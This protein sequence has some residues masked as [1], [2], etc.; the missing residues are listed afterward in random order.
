M[1]RCADPAPGCYAARL[2]LSHGERSGIS[3]RIGPAPRSAGFRLRPFPWRR[4]RPRRTG[5]AGAGPAEKRD[6]SVTEQE[7]TTPSP[8]GSRDARPG[9]R[10]AGARAPRLDA[11]R[12]PCG[13]RGHHRRSSA[14]GSRRHVLRMDGQPF[15]VAGPAD[16]GHLL[17]DRGS[18]CHGRLSPPAHPPQLQVPPPDP[19]CARR[20]R[21]RRRRGP[22]HRLGGH[23]PQ[24]PRLLR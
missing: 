5:G 4:R 21:L 23:P 22:G 18:R 19:S 7:P 12:R 14:H 6:M 20:A 15:A 8:A 17:R 1:C 24:A 9:A 13:Q 11:A 2:L 3:A 10:G 16:P